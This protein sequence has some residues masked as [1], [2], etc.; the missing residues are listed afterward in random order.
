M[1][2]AVKRR[3]ILLSACGSRT[4]TL[5]THL[6]QPAEKTFKKIVDTL[7]KHFSPKPSEIVERYKFHS[8][9]RKE[10]EGVAVYVAELSKLTGLC[11]FG[12]TLNQKC[13]EI[14]WSVVENNK[15]IQQRLLAERELTLEKAEEIAL[16]E[17]LATKHVVDI[18]SETTPSNINQVNAQDENRTKDTKDRR[19]D[20]ECYRCGEKH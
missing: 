2:D 12:E 16:G 9:N 18:Q 10:D 17:E 14:S 20:S 3:A 15:K 4:Y 8:Q 5:A 13:Y 7:E 19:Q 11:N 6:L 1:D